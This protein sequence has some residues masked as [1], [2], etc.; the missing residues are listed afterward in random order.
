MG[1]QVLALR[2][3]REGWNAETASGASFSS[4]AVVLTPPVPQSL[5]ILDAG[6]ITLDAAERAR[7]TSIE[8]ARC[9]AVMAVLKGPSRIPPPGGFAPAAGPIVWIADNQTKGISSE[10][11]ITIHARHAFS[12]EH[13]D[14]DRQE[15]GRLLLDA[16][17]EWLGADVRTFQVQGWRYSKPLRVD[18]RRC[19]VLSESPPLVLAG[20]AFAGPRV[21]GAALSGWAAAEAVLLNSA[22]SV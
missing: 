18:E 4:K 16:A 15:S 20:D 8:Y 2:R 1:M 6:E 7:L 21:E 12:V 11:A 10:P 22:D 13:W 9:L 5:A 17:K 14:R 3:S 19:A